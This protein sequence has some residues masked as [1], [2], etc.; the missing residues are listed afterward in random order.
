MTAAP[1]YI[2][3]NILRVLVDGL[4]REGWPAPARNKPSDRGGLTRG[5]ITARSWGEYKH[6]GR[7][8]TAD[9]LNAI[10]EAEALTFYL[11]RYVLRPHF[12]QVLDQK[13]RALLVDWSFTS[14]S[15]DPVKALQRSLRDRGYNPGPIDGVIGPQT[16]AALQADRDPRRLYRDV[17]AARLRFYVGLAF[18]HDVFAF[19]DAH[20][21]TQLH[22][23]AGWINRSLEFLP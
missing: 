4:R 15:D 2:D 9:E 12:D 19:L 22:N 16:I 23:L 18:D 10:T 5:G 7:P 14:W 1:P 21:E 8:A 3:P 17:L 20:P 6:L 13:L 11:Q